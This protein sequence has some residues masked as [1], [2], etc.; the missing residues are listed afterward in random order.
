MAPSSAW[1]GLA[2]GNSR[3]HWGWFWGTELRQAWDSPHLSPATIDRLIE[4]RLD[5]AACPETQSP[6]ALSAALP[7]RLASVVPEQTAAWLR[8]DRSQAVTLANIPLQG[9]YPT[10]G[11]DRALAV[12]GALQAYG[13]PALVIDGGTALTFTGAA[14]GRL[15][16]G[17]ILPGLALQLR[18]LTQ[19]TAAL[20]DLAPIAA[21]PTRWARST[22]DAIY[23]GVLHALTAGV[24]DFAEA[25]LQ[26]F[27]S[28]AIAFTGGDGAALHA[29]LT[30]TAPELA[31][32]AVVDAHLVLRG[33]GALG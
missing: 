30:Q 26:Q 27:P 6:A 23:S 24:R 17:A 8:Y 3:L 9:L 7:L 33:I 21:L 31:S 14:D 1:L 32:L 13:A 4:Q 25:W 11:I 16:G 22:P 15:V 18:S 20:P 5:F 29:L 2:I 28:S 19:H 12:W 10:L